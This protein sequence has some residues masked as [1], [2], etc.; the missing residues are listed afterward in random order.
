[1]DLK[2]TYNRIA[3]DWH[4]DHQ[5]DDW[6]IE[7]TDA[8]VSHIPQGGRVLDVGCGGGFKS[9]Y[10]TNKGLK[11]TGI[12]FSESMVA[13]ARRE[14]ADAEF[15]VMDMRDV[16][17]LNGEFDGIFVQAALLHIP[18]K[19]APQIV[20]SFANKLASHGALYIAVKGMRSGGAEEEIVE[21]NDYGYAYERFF[22]YWSREEI[23]SMLEKAGLRVVYGKEKPSAETNWI[24]VIARK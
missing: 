12:D 3:E 8:F 20:R 10:L 2:D 7:G 13:I 22:S 21:E 23:V 14:V 15:M 5:R 18:K 6:W 19:E 4:R 24:Q 9:K 17:S 16:P 11:V 1:M